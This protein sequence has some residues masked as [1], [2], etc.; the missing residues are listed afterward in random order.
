[1]STTNT[2]TNS[3]NNWIS[4]ERLFRAT[5]DKTC[6][7]L[8]AKY[9]GEYYKKVYDRWS[10][11]QI[12]SGSESYLAVLSFEKETEFIN[13]L[14]V[15]EIHSWDASDRARTSQNKL[16]FELAGYDKLLFEMSCRWF[17]YM[18]CEQPP[19]QRL[20]FVVV[21]IPSVKADP[22]II[23]HKTTE[24]MDRTLGILNNAMRA[25]AVLKTSSVTVEQA[26]VVGL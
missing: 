17:P 4:K 12:D 23:L 24:E 26:P 21:V 14:H 25:A 11:S 9:I 8:T 2:N 13:C 18:T 6:G 7:L 20:S 15:K 22:I 5:H 19:R 3:C 1:M 10:L 16:K